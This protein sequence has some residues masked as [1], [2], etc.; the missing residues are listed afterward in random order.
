MLVCWGTS[1][2]LSSSEQGKHSMSSS[3]RWR[4]MN[5]KTLFTCHCQICPFSTIMCDS[6]IISLPTYLLWP[7]KNISLSN[8]V[9]S[10]VIKVNQK[11]L[12]H[13]R[14]QLQGNQKQSPCV[15]GCGM[16]VR[17]YYKSLQ[18]LYL[19]VFWLF[20]SCPCLIHFLF[21]E[22]GLLKLLIRT[23]FHRSGDDFWN[24]IQ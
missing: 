18:A 21:H 10:C 1:S 17:Q 15:A 24:T 7:S 14:G 6:E 13:G 12:N 2:A 3:N 4:V 8:N 11:T 9:Y 5:G 20:L 23:L 19:I 16:R 22:A